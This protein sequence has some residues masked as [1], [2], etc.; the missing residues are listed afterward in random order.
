M[1][2]EIVENYNPRDSRTDWEKYLLELLRT[3]SNFD[4]WKVFEQ[5]HINSLKPDFV[6][7]NPIKV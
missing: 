5:P 6:L 1:G 4:G 7:L 2:A 3:N